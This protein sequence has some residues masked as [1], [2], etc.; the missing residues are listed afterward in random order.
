MNKSELKSFATYARRELLEKVAL[1]A[2]VFGMEKGSNI[3]LV[4]NGEKL[5]VNGLQYPTTMKNAFES[6]KRQYELK[7]Y[8]Q[9]MEEVAYTWFNR[10]IAL[11][12]MEIHEYLPERVNVLSSSSGKIEPD[13]LLQYHS[14][15]LE[16]DK[17]LIRDLMDR[18]DQEE[19]FR[20]LF[21]AQCNALQPIL[22]F[23]F[24]KIDD[25]TELLLPDYLLDSESL[26]NKLVNNK[27][28]TSSFSEVEVV[29]WLY[30]YYNTEPKAN[31]DYKVKNGDKVD[32]Y[33]IPAKTQLFTPRWIV[34]YMVENSLGS[35]WLNSYPNSM[36][37]SQ[38]DYYVESDIQI[39]E[40][41]N[42]LDAING[43]N[44]A[45]EKIK[46]I[47]PACGSGHI[48]VYAFDLL[49]AMYEERGYESNEIPFLILEQNLYG[50][51]IDD[52][53][54]QLS[55]FALLMKAREK[56][57][58]IFR[59]PPK[60]NV[61]SIQ[62]SNGLPVDDLVR[63]ISQNET[64]SK[65]ILRLLE[66][67][68]NAKNFGSILIPD[69]ID[70]EKYL[71]RI[72]SLYNEEI[73][74]LFDVEA[75][76]HLP[77]LEYLLRQAQLLNDKYDVVI[78][79][80]PYLGAGAMNAQLTDYTKRVFPDSKSDLFAVFMER[81][82]IFVKDNG[83]QSQINQHSWM[84][85]SSYEILRKNILNSQTFISMLH[86][87]PHAFEEINGEVVQSTSY[88][89]R[90]VVFSNYKAKYYRLTDYP[91]T[92]EKECA[93]INK[94]D[95]YVSS[96]HDFTNITGH[97]IS[98]WASN[99]LK[100]CFES[101][102]TFRN[103][104]PPKKGLDTN[105]ESEKFFRK[106]FEVDFQKI[107]INKSDP[108]DN[109]KWFEIDKGGGARKW[110]G[111]RLD[112]INYENKGYELKNKTK[113]AN[114]R[115]ESLYFCNSLTY[116]VIS[117]K[118][119]SFRVSL[120]N[121]LFDQGGPNCFPD[122]ENRNYIL[123]L[124]NSKVVNSI[125]ET[126]APT[127]NFTVGDV[128]KI[129]V[130][131]PTDKN[132][133]EKINQFVDDNIILSKQNWD[134]NEV[135]WD[136]VSH[137]FILN[138]SSSGLLSDAFDN[139]RQLTNNR[140]NKLIANEEAINEFFIKL[141]GLQN[142]LGATVTNDDISIR[143]AN[144]QNDS[145]SFLSYFVGCL[146]G[147][148]SHD[149]DGFYFLNSHLKRGN[150]QS[151]PHD[152]GMIM[153]SDNAYFENDIMARLKDF[154]G[155]TFGE[156]MIEINLQWLGDSIG[157]RKNDSHEE[158][159]RRYFLEEFYVDHCK[160][161]NNR[162]IYWLV[163]S[164]ENKGMRILINLHR[165]QPSTMATIRFEY[166]QAIQA[167]YLNEVETIDMRL[168]N[169]SL[170]ATE[171]RTYEKKKEDFNKRIEELTKFDKILAEYANAQVQIDL[172]EGVKVNYE[173]FKGVLAKIK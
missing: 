33:E 101:N 5:I 46:L 44:L 156:N 114:I 136:F 142:E 83:Y 67:F 151:N 109:Y 129:P 167:K 126:I 59:N 74:S 137:P 106:W 165:Y 51:D 76:N 26:I 88:I 73:Q 117:T 100:K 15:E 159:L 145:K 14:M 11:R 160:T 57:R 86:L 42:H 166:L 65:E 9:V 70:I 120:S 64:D 75:I 81:C 24:E 30:Q 152:H 171:K 164:G 141:Y 130:I 35:T 52:R 23:L 55:A 125:L 161:Y 10:I 50:V 104:A 108:K 121:S 18:G 146:L 37:K 53:A 68:K 45:P 40:V 140:V 139:W 25:F 170:L 78:T 107:W 85:L 22:S 32:K 20:K 173:K 72:K 113:K 87:G 41:Q 97:P 162:P 79:N 155:L 58:R 94:K 127:I 36:L 154:L 144:R 132:S 105:G 143:Q 8:E 131:F 43:N 28:L 128:A 77:K 38:M 49:Y 7:G 158:R 90:K 95:E 47:D 31:V 116:G 163:D 66:D 13:I 6:L 118:S 4:L 147:R 124:G 96:Q 29:G 56:S 92:K 148:F 149:S 27:A 123:A 2:K 19:A 1:R 150:Y 60:T 111:N 169:P 103:I 112:I 69:K 135:S 71:Q 153:F 63:L 138:K 39:E 115:N 84:F 62:E 157:L 12:Y 21:I 134:S 102:I 16:V 34:R 61:I 17:V 168:T 172:D 3:S 98:Y 122:Q 110:Y 93:F 89:I 82:N 91:T 54:A 119:F 133:V 80:P 99:Q 48:L